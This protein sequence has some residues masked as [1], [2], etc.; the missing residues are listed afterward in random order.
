[1]NKLFSTVIFSSL[2]VLATQILNPVQV[3]AADELI[4]TYQ[5]GVNVYISI[6]SVTYGNRTSFYAT[7]LIKRITSSGKLIQSFKIGFNHD[8]GQWIYWI[9]GGNGGHKVHDDEEEGKILR[10]L[11]EH[12]DEAHM[13]E[14]ILIDRLDYYPNS[15]V[16]YDENP[17][18]FYVTSG[19]AGVSYLYLPSVRIQKNNP[20]YCQ[21][22][23]IFVH[24]YGDKNGNVKQS[25]ITSV[26]R[27]DCDKKVTYKRNKD[28]NWESNIAND[29][30]YKDATV[31]KS[32]RE[33][34][35]ALFR[36]IYGIDFYDK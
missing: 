25:K 29:P 9:E 13:T 3:E 23:G 4:F 1:M 15:Y 35:N 22:F 17:D 34:A 2:F 28:G 7:A 26:I 27:Y 36:A 8:E 31:G 14:D 11:I 10:W 30:V 33:Y 16:Y 20:P 19:G 21:I 24:V 32:S 18:Y 12:R 6:E 5:N